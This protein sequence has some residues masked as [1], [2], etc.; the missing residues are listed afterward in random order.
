MRVLVVEDSIGSSIDIVLDLVEAGH[1]VVRCQPIGAEL[2]PCA[3][4]SAAGAN[5][6]LDD[7][8][9]VVV[10]VHDGSED[11][12]LREL[13]VVCAG[14]KGIPIVNVGRARSRVATVSTTAERLAETLAML[15]PARDG[16]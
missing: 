6:P 14:R 4:L 1:R 16:P 9:D 12:T 8:V 3:G 10:Q 2:N 7:P 11:L 13:G 5:C 15:G